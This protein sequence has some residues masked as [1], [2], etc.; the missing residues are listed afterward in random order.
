LT[1]ITDNT[2]HPPTEI[3]HAFCRRELPPAEM[4]TLSDHLVDCASCRD[5]VQSL[6][7][8]IPISSHIDRFLGDDT[9]LHLTEDEIADAVADIALTG[10][11]QAHLH[12]CP[13]CQSEVDDARRFAF[14]LA[15]VQ[16]VQT[17]TRAKLIAW[18]VWSLAA[19]AGIAIAALVGH[20]FLHRAPTPV[21]VVAELR[22]GDS[23]IGLTADG[24]LSGAPALS[25]DDAALLTS[26]LSSHSL[27]V[28]AQ[29]AHTTGNMRGRPAVPDA[30]APL[31]PV[32][33]ITLQAPQLSWQALPNATSYQVF[34]YSQSFQLAAQSPTLTQPTW[35][36]DHPLTPGQTYTWVIKAATPN[37][38]VQSP[39]P[40]A[41]EARFTVADAAMLARIAGA[42]PS[43]L[44][45][46]TLY[47][48]NG[49]TSLAR[50]EITILQQ[51]NPNSSVVQELANSLPP[52][53]LPNSTKPAQ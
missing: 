24:R 40:P 11:A 53:S 23:Q 34:V 12:S 46:A 52:Q 5:R 41:P 17:R 2:M 32:D 35:T 49:M 38:I 22:D 33:E 43:H 20:S 45:L 30:F 8:N 14:P 36:L 39:R 50:A 15:L 47:A 42:Q 25:A 37:G 10:D 3:L 26:A 44:L 4:L 18:P 1:H 29:T 51:Q 27:P 9:A 13:T 48:Q 28:I 19:A 21:Q 6:A 7:T 16:P 31:T